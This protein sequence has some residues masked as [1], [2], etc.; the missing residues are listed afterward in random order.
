MR[1]LYD[2]RLIEFHPANILAQAVG[3]KELEKVASFQTIILGVHLM[4]I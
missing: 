2:A 4:F 3:P 1:A